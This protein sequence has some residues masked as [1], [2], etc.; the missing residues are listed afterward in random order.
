[1][2]DRMPSGYYPVAL[3]LSG[4]RC[5]I[6]GGGKV[7]ERKLNGLLESGADR[8]ELISPTVT[9]AI[10]RQAA[11]GRLKWSRRPYRQGDIEGVWLLIA[12]TDNRELNAS[13]AEEADRLGVL[14]N[15]ADDYERG[16]FIAPSVI[17]RGPLLIAVTTSGAS[18][19]LAKSLAGELDERYGKR[20]G[21]AIIKLGE[22]RKLVYTRMEDREWREEVLRRAAKESLEPWT[23]NIALEDW[24]ERLIDRT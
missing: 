15:I 8:I 21:E 3:R 10:E 16:S 4:K 9:D 1:M 23:E 2:E 5:M 18:P 7:A 11:A 17:R 19:A 13:V 24:L 20:Y 22:L 12:A 6:I 14:S